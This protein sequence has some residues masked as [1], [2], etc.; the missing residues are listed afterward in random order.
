MSRD[1]GVIRER[2][3]LERL[4]ASIDAVGSTAGWPSAILAA[5][6]IA[7]AA[8][9]RR[10]SRGSHCRADHPVAADPPRRSFLVRDPAGEIRFLERGPFDAGVVDR[11]PSRPSPAA[12][13]P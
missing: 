5:R 13:V 7:A 1:C 4:L 10:E 9:A 3:G 11:R 12:G 8:L 6:L 2:A